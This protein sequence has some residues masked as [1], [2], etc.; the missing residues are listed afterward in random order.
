LILRYGNE[1]Y[2]YQ[3]A[4]KMQIRKV[5]AVPPCPPP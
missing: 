3:P 1:T 4:T 2:T 5:L